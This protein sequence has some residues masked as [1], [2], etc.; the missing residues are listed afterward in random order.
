MKR[1]SVLLGSLIGVVAVTVSSLALWGWLTYERTYG[2]TREAL[3]QLRGLCLHLE[4]YRERQGEYPSQLADLAY[5]KLSR[6][7]TKPLGELLGRDA[8]STPI[9]YWSNG[10]SYAV[11]SKG[12]DGE[13]DAS[14]VMEPYDEAW[15]W[16]T[17]F[18]NGRCMQWYR[19]NSDL[20]CV[21]RTVPRTEL[22]ALLRALEAT[23]R[24]P[25]V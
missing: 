22:I 12:A 17:L 19:G 21:E 11:W 20:S 9:A 8:W 18:F 10:T 16:D 1:L 13:T 2:S 24:A 23:I 3:G 6:D 4:D 5:L 7:Y 14:W 15:D 25:G